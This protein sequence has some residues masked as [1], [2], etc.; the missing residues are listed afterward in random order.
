MNLD[1]SGDVTA[2]RGGASMNCMFES[3]LPCFHG[4]SEIIVHGDR[5]LD[6]RVV[7]YHM[8]PSSWDYLFIGR[9]PS[10]R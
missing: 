8:K 3:A 6:S 9:N 4:G 1:I 5:P 10:K 2:E 7:I